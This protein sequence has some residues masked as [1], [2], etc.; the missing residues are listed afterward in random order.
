MKHLARALLGVTLLPCLLNAAA[1]IDVVQRRSTTTKAQGE[2]TDIGKTEITVKPRNGDPV[3]IPAN[4]IQL[5]DWSDAPA[6]FK[7]ARSDESAGRLQKALDGYEKVVSENRAKGEGLKTDLEFFIARTLGKLAQ[8]DT[9]RLA[10]AIEKLER[11]KQQHADSFRYYECL[12]ALGRLYLEQGELAKSKATFEALGQSPFPENK[13]SAQIALGRLS[14]RENNVAEALQAFE[15]VG[16]MPAAGPAEAAKK[17]EA[18]LGVAHCLQL[19]KEYDK[20][21]ALLNEIIASADADD[22]ALQ[23]EAY[24]RMGDCCEAAGK[25]KE[26]MLAYLHV[27]VLFPSEKGLHAESL[28]H[29]SKLWNTVGQPDRAQDAADRL[30]SEYPKSAWAEK[31]ET[32]PAP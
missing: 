22:A 10:E 7:V 3:T 26:A 32:R 19:Q 24:V 9:T 28:F 21:I 11:F 16:R 6:I 12:D 1:A 2:V 31:L 20:A 30:T 8:G 25:P 14:L 4:D 5:V 29:L 15:A 13:M 23:A 27:D 17:Q 18:R